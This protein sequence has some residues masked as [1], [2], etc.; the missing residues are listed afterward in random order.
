MVD[1]GRGAGAPG[2]L[3]SALS[4]ADTVMDST[5]HQLT[6]ASAC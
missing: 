5:E 6:S 2:S 4:H 1:G 3:T